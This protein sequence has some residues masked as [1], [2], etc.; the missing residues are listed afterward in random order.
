[1][2]SKKG[3]HSPPLKILSLS[4]PYDLTEDDQGSKFVNKAGD[5]YLVY[6]TTYYLLDPDG[7][8]NDYIEVYMLGFDCI[9][10]NPIKKRQFDAK[11][12]DTV[13]SVFEGFMD[14]NPNDAYI[15]VCYNG[16]GKARNRRITFGKWFNDSDA[17]DI[18]ERHHSTINFDN[19]SL[20]SSFIIRTDNPDRD[21]LLK[22][23]RYTVKK[24]AGGE[25]D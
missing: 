24:T 19:N 22:A 17:S 11:T 4:N 6:I 14:Q 2:L 10:A 18:Y 21:E 8:H 12:R 16:D 25:E 20:Y 23:F 1:M 5:E 15:F 13:L 3:N 7:D 9:L